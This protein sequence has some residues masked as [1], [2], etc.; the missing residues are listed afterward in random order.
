MTKKPGRKA[1]DMV[2][3]IV[4]VPPAMKAALEKAAKASGESANTVVRTALRSF[5]ALPTE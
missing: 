4:R 1:V 2:A 5:L 3:L